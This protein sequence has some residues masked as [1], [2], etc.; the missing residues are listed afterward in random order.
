MS[1]VSRNLASLETGGAATGLV[2]LTQ[3]LEAGIGIPK[4][5][6]LWVALDKLAEMR[7]IID[8]AARAALASPL[9]TAEQKALVRENLEITHRAIPFTQEDIDD[10]RRRGAD[11]KLK[12]SERD[13][14]FT[15]YANKIN[16]G[17]TPTSTQIDP[18]AIE[19]LKT[20]PDGL[21]EA[22]DKKYGAGSANRVLGQQ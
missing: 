16:L 10:A 13:M 1:G 4:G 8:S 21:R 9:Y 17:S 15:E 14:T 3:S 20:D 22:F 11:K 12:P 18:R 2:G 19:R 7:K 6:Q 5:A